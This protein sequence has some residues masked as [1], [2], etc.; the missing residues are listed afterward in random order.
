M[1]ALA[2]APG[3][4]VYSLSQPKPHTTAAHH[5]IPSAAQNVHGIGRSGRTEAIP[6]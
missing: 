5:A 6:G 2:L 4:L 1:D 3:V